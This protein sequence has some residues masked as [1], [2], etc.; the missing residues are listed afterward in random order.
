MFSEL[1]RIYILV[2][3]TNAIPA[4][5]QKVKGP[6][7]FHCPQCKVTATTVGD[8][9]MHVKASHTK[10]KTNIKR[11]E[12]QTRNSKRKEDELL[13]QE[14]KLSIKAVEETLDTFLNETLEEIISLIEL[15]VYHKTL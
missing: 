14:H 12:V 13:L 9:R 6:K 1:P 3:K 4:I 15:K 2:C 7:P 11:L 10:T 8:L 5:K